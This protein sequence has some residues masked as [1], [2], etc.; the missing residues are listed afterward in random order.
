[1]AG[2]GGGA[3]FYWCRYPSDY[4]G[5]ATCNITGAGSKFRFVWIDA[6]KMAIDTFVGLLV[7]SLIMLPIAIAYWCYIETPHSNFFNNSMD[8]NVLLIC[9]GVVTTAPLLCFTAAAKGCR[10][11]R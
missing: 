2:L 5:H 8:L 9:A 4:L 10:L 11:K 7:E 3:C 1:M 6:Q